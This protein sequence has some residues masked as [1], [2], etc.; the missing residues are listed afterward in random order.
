MNPFDYYIRSSE[1][2]SWNNA[3]GAAALLTACNTKCNLIPLK[4]ERNAFRRR[5][6]RVSS[7]KDV[8]RSKFEARTDTYIATPTT[9]KVMEAAQGQQ[10]GAQGLDSAIVQY[11]DAA[12]SVTKTEASKAGLSTGAMIGIGAG[13]VAVILLGA[14]L[15]RRK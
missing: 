6:A 15:L 7:C 9:Q 11:E 14:V 4:P 1:E 5:K 3:T 10:Q 12:S 2:E 8:C 13:V